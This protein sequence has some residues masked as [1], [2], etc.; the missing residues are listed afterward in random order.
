MKIFPESSFFQEGRAPALP[1]LAEVRDLNLKTGNVAATNL[2]YPP[3]VIIPSLR[4]VIKYGLSVS[5]VEAQ[6]QIMVR[7]ESQG[8]IPVPEIFGWIE[9]N[10]QTFIYMSLIEGDTLA[11]RWGGLSDDEKQAICEELHQYVKLLRTLEQDPRDKY[12][13]NL[14]KNPLTDIYVIDRP[15]LVGPFQGEDAVNQLQDACGIEIDDD[16]VS[17]IVFT[18]NDLISPNIMITLDPNPKVAALVD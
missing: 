15:E 14:D 5:I 11:D 4:V 17:S 6:T 12:I 3:S 1:S 13:G 7:E 2:N 9:D 8:R 16:I 10:G 18:H